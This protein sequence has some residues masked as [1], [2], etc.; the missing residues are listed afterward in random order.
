[1]KRRNERQKGFTLIELLVVLIV[2]AV[3]AAVTVPALTSYL[4]DARE[5]KA[6]SEAQVCV[7]AATEWAAVQ[8]TAL[9]SQAYQT[10]KSFKDAYK[11]ESNTA[12]WSTDYEAL[13]IPAPTVTGTPALAEGDGQ[14]F[15]RPETAPDTDTTD[16]TMKNTV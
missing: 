16:T 11:A 6:V 13:N 5:K 1:M 2:I 15:L 4:D 10:N 14:Y 8:R 3:L 12:K 7:T 9:I